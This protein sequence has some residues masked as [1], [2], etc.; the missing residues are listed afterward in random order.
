[1]VVTPKKP[2]PVPLYDYVNAGVFDDVLRVIAHVVDNS[3][4]LALDTRRDREVL[5][6]RLFAALRAE[7]L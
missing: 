2:R 1:M 5:R 3:T 6:D 4:S 7:L